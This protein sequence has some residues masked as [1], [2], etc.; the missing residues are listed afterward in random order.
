MA[1]GGTL[2]VRF[3]VQS[4]RHTVHTR[5]NVFLRKKLLSFTKIP[6]NPT[7]KTSKRFWVTHLVMLFYMYFEKHQSL[8]FK[9]SSIKLRYTHPRIFKWSSTWSSSSTQ[10]SWAQHRPSTEKYAT[11]RKN[12]VECQWRAVTTSVEGWCCHTLPRVEVE[13]W[14]KKHSRIWGSVCKFMECSSNRS[15]KHTVNLTK[16]KQNLIASHK[17]SNI[18]WLF[19]IKNEH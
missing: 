5:G 4:R 9:F 17:Y 12:C 3:H 11:L 16:H 18:L 1:I 8:M 19:T 13:S 2:A 7:N 10:P 6:F 15:E 14:M